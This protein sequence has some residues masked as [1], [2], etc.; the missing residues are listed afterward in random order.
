MIRRIIALYVIVVGL[1]LTLSACA[2]LSDV[3]CRPAGQCPNAPDGIGK[4]H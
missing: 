4:D 2:N 1:M 3:L